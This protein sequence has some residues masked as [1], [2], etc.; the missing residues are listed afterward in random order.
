M[1]AISA[2]KKEDPD[3]LEFAGYKQQSPDVLQMQA[4]SRRFRKEIPSIAEKQMQSRRNQ[5]DS[6]YK[7]A[8]QSGRAAASSRGLLYSGLRQKAE[9]DVLGQR[10]GALSSARR[11]IN[12]DLQRQAD[13]MEM[14]TLGRDIEFQGGIYAEQDVANQM[15]RQQELDA[16]RNRQAAFSAL[17]QLGGM[18]AARYKG[19]QQQPQPGSITGSIMSPS[20]YAGF[21]Q[22]MASRDELMGYYRG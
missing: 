8:M 20:E 11:D 3:S 22:P 18:V 9:A 21:R 1:P 19:Q 17:G 12:E 14:G 4:L 6:E 10:L 2:S 5:I 16:L 15:R 7:N 13:A